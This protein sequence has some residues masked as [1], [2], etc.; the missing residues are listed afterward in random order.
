MIDAALPVA[1]PAVGFN[2]GLDGAVDVSVEAVFADQ[3]EDAGLL[4]HLCH[5]GLEAGEPQVDPGAL[6]EVEDLRE[7]GC[8]LG[9]DEVDALQIEDHSSE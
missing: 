4:E 6:G 1:R 9:V 7:L 2:L 8:A 3:L 5:V